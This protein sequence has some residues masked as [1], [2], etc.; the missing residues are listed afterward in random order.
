VIRPEA[1]AARLAQEPPA[2]LPTLVWVASDEPL[3]RIEAAD[4]VRAGARRLGVDEREVVPVERGLDAAQLHALGGARSLFASRRLVELRFAGRPARELGE[5]LAEAAGTDDDGCLW[6]VTSPRLDRT[7]TEAAW[8]ARLDRAGWVVSIPRVERGELPRWL[9]ERLARQ[10][11]QADADVLA[12]IAERVEGNLLA[13][14]QEVRKLAL[15]LPPG[16]LSREAVREAVLDVARWDA[17]D[18]VGAALA[19]DPRRVRRCLAGLRAEGAA[20]PAVLWPLADAVRTLQRL[21][22]AEAAG[23]SAGAALREL[24]V[25]G[26]RERTY[27]QALRRLAPPAVQRLLRAC[28]VADRIAKGVGDGDEWQWLEAVALGLAGRPPLTLDDPVL[29]AA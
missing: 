9:R 26:E 15:L 8:F 27:P 19:G 16:R 29:A 23:R 24:R 6:L 12:D 4:A 1:L 20:A 10:G 3:L 17:F 7:S 22:L 2:R 5:A 18:L 28:A 13:A 21:A 25:W 14:D 11:Q